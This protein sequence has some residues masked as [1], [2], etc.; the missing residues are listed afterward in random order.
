MAYTNKKRVQAEHDRLAELYADIPENKRKLV[1]GLI[2]QAARMR[3]S[4]DICWEDI[5]KKG[6]TELQTKSNGAE[7]EV[8]RD[9]SK[10]FTATDRS[11]QAIIKML[12]DLLPSVSGVSK[13]DEFLGGGD[14]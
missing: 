11:Y 2:D 3:V 6:R 4:L 5:R 14:D 8:E 1:E 12:N 9:V 10:I 7:A 13:L